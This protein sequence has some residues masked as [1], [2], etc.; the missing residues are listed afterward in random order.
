MIFVRHAHADWR[1][2]EQQSL[3]ATGR[4]DAEQVADL[5]GGFPIGAIYASPYPR[6]VETVEP[7][8]RRL[9]LPVEVEPDLRER[10]LA[11]GRVEDFEAAARWAWDH[12]D[13][14]QPGGESNRAAL[15]RSFAV[16]ERLQPRS[17]DEEVV[18][19]THGSLMAILLHHVDP[20]FGFADWQRMT[21]PDVYRL[22]P[23]GQVERLWGTR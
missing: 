5:L 14:A 20:E 3:S 13:E 19:A 18:L 11:P 17:T 16:V 9:G 22:G 21:F 12:P 8:A 10:R 6:A 15:A 4:A 1:P 23:D 7:L 2:D